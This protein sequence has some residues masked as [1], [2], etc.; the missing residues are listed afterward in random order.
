MALVESK[1]QD[2]CRTFPTIGPR[3]DIR[4]ITATITSASDA[5]LASSSKGALWSRTSDDGWFE[6]SSSDEHEPPCAFTAA[7]AAAAAA[8]AAA[9]A[10]ASAAGGSAEPT[11]DSAANAEH[12]RGGLVTLRRPTRGA[13]VPRSLLSRRGRVRLPWADGDGD[14]ATLAAALGVPRWAAFL[15]NAHLQLGV[16]A[17][18]LAAI[19]RHAPLE[20][21]EALHGAQ[22]SLTPDCPLTPLVS[23]PS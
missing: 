23:P 16:P 4:R 11:F 10:D 19:F 17:R 7:A 18:F 6:D 1:L 15:F 9:A 3:L 22:P 20:L 13:L 12:S 8:G 2:L 14:A 5:D 21:R